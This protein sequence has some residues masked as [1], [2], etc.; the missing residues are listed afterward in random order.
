MYD[1]KERKILL[2]P[3]IDD[4]IEWSEDQILV[5]ERSGEHGISD[6]TQYYIN[7]KGEKLYPWL[8]EKGFAIV[9]KPNKSLV[10][11]V[12]V[13]KYT[14]LSGN[15]RSYFPHNGEKYERTFLYGIYSAK[16]KFLV[17]ME[18]EKI[19]EVAENLF[20]CVKDGAVTL[21]QVE[22]ADF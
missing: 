8:L 5:Y 19:T 16:G 1:S 13:S 9:E 10:T 21:I 15:P 22:E 12:A 14:E 7:S 18:Y 2:E 4:F 11:I 17:P 3:S 20:G 6:F